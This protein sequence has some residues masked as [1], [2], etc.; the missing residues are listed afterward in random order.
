LEAVDDGN[1]DDVFV[2]PGTFSHDHVIVG[3]TTLSGFFVVVTAA[4]S[5]QP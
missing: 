3:I 5:G 4:V 1:A 2:L